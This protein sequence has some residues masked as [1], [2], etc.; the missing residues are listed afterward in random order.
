[1][2]SLTTLLVPNETVR[3]T[4]DSIATFGLRVLERPVPAGFCGQYHA[5]YARYTF[6]PSLEAAHTIYVRAGEVYELDARNQVGNRGA[7]ATTIDR[8]GL[9]QAIAI[10]R[11]ELGADLPVTWNLPTTPV[12]VT[13]ETVGA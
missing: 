11:D 13:R 2:V 7:F 12:A 8:D 3:L 5:V 1:M 9:E 10:L 4:R 6:T